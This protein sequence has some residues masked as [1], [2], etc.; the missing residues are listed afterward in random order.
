[1]EK[2]INYFGI[3]IKWWRKNNKVSQTE[4]AKLIDKKTS[5]VS[6]YENGISVPSLGVITHISMILG[7]S[8]DEIMYSDLS[9][10]YTFNIDAKNGNLKGNLKGNLIN[11]KITIKTEIEKNTEIEVYHTQIS[12]MQ[13]RIQEVKNLIKVLAENYNFNNDETKLFKCYY[14]YV[15]YLSINDLDDFYLDEI[16]VNILKEYEQKLQRLQLAIYEDLFNI[17]NIYNIILA[18]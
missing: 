7:Y 14:R 5:V 11:E 9:K 16:D 4:F 17:T 18:K 8:V 6:A 3:N 15:K 2:K 13:F 12:F 1:M 10:K